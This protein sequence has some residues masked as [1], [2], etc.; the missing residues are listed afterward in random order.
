MILLDTH[1]LIWLAE[2][3]SRL[4]TEARK[5]ADEALGRDELMVSA[6]SFWETAMLQS[7]GRLEIDLPVADWRVALLRLG[8]GEVTIAGEVGID[9]AQL[10]AFHGDPA[11]RLITATAKRLGATLLTA[12]ERILAWSGDLT[13]ADART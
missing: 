3:S 8:I 9:A 13:R 5:Q 6:I 10:A 1:A 2:A 11:D 4:G 7:R 12:D